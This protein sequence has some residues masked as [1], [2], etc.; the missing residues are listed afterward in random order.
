MTVPDMRLHELKVYRGVNP[1][2]ED[3]DEYWYR[4]LDEVHGLGTAYE[5]EPADFHV[6]FA[7]CYHL[8][9]KGVGGAR[10]YAQYLRPVK[11]GQAH[12]AVILFH[13]YRSSCGD[14]Q[15][16]LGFIGA[17]YSV[18]ALDCRGQGGLSEDCG[19][20]KGNT[21]NGHI[22]RG[23]AD[24]PEKLLYRQIF[25]DT[26]QLTR[27]LMAMDDIDE[28][29]I[30]VSGYS[31]GGAL[32]LA[33]AAL[34]PGIKKVVAA[35]PFLC[36]YKRAWEMDPAEMAYAE[37]K[38]FFRNFDPV[39]KMEDEIFMRLGY[40]DVQHLAPRIKADVLMATALLDET[41][42]PSTQFAA[43]N[44]ITAKKEMV[45]YPD[46]G[47]EN[48]PGFHDRIFGFMMEL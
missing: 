42:P 5:L 7:A 37:L 15:D 13:G 14:W 23:L 21:D 40:I 46:L 20:V 22:I 48:L 31:Q 39:H 35:Y 9:F 38:T 30:G 4:A 10:I 36:D 33:C 12:P 17:G 41:C 43:Y 44:K 16:K 34:E 19:E 26:V 25:L 18:A 32:A 2:P 6:P 47:H 45:V 8:Y 27:I 24:S 28:K 1:K 11:K 29:R 3:F